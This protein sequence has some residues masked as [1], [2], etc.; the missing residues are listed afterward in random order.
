LL[1]AL[2]RVYHSKCFLC[3]KAQYITKTTFGFGTSNGAETGFAF[4][5]NLLC[6]LG[7]P[8]HFDCA[9]IDG[10]TFCFLVH[11]VFVD[12]IKLLAVDKSMNMYRSENG[13]PV[14]K[15]LRM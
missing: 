3:T 13:V 12:C 6:S 9:V 1:L 11:P 14:V 8:L 10:N 2:T 5:W 4:K 15:H 7:K